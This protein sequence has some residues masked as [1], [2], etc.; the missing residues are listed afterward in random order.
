MIGS[1]DRQTSHK[2]L[3]DEHAVEWIFV[4]SLK[5]F[6]SNRIGFGEREACDSGMLADRRDEY[7]GM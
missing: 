6:S 2:R 3:C 1:N 4:E 7:C 5:L